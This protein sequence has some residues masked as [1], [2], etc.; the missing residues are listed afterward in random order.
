MHSRSKSQFFGGKSTKNVT[1]EIFFEDDDEKKIQAKKLLSEDLKPHE[2]RAIVS[3]FLHNDEVFTH[4][5]KHMFG[6]KAQ[7]DEN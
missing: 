7:E 6:N 2:K 3:Y 5:C 1:K 4:L